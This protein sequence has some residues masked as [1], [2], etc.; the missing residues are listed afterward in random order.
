MKIKMNS[1]A[2]K[3][4]CIAFLVAVSMV[5]ANFGDNKAYAASSDKSSKKIVVKLSYCT[6]Q[7]TPKGKASTKFAELVHKRAGDRIDVQVFPSSQLYGDKEE[8]QAL[9]ANNAQIIVPSITKLVSMNP[10][11]QVV[12]L[13][14]L[15]RNNQAV[16]NFW[17]GKGGEIL[18]KKLEKQGLLGL[19]AWNNAPINII[20]KKFFKTPQDFKGV[21]VRIPAG[22]VTT[23]VFKALGAGAT[24]IPF[25]EVYT[26]LQQGVADAAIS[27]VNNFD[28]EKYYEV[29]KYLS[30]IDLQRIEYIALTNTQFWNGLS[31]D[32]K[33]I[34]TECMNEA[35]K[36]ERSISDDLNKNSLELMKSRGVQVYTM[37]DKEKKVLE[38]LFVPV[39]KK[40]TPK[41]GEDLVAMARQAGK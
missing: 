3:I 40:W 2:V 37:T 20:G 1:S 28:T 16:Y 4:T 9:M 26:S 17:D 31:A 25:S 14:F 30:I 33:K 19:A 34:L 15:F 11:Y 24:T 12:D 5:F 29:T 22:Q 13:P 21:K 23:D 35:A 10:S 38:D 8:I 36:Y 39:Y 18:L 32:V 41:I 6:S 7:E 27:S